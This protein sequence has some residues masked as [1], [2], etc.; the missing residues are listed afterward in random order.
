VWLLVYGTFLKTVIANPAAVLTDAAFSA[1]QTSGWTTVLGTLAFA[2]QI[3]CDFWAYSM[4]A[5]GSGRLLGIEFIWNFNQP[6]F[7]TSIQDFWRRWHISL[8]RWLRDYLYIPLGG[9]RKGRV[10]TYVNLIL[11][12]LLGGLWHGA[13]WSFVLW[14][15][16]HGLALAV[17]RAYEELLGPSRPRV[18]APIGWAVTM[19]VVLVGWFVFRCASW[20]MIAGMGRSLGNL[21]WTAGHTRTLATLACLAAPVFIVEVWQYLRRDLLAPLALREPHFAVL[22][23][24]MLALTIIMFGRFNYAFIYFQF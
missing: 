24:T 10:R 4:I 17:Q 18:P 1:Q 21:A 3:Y 15:L 20:A 19:L 8:S 23:G 16:L 5:R 22:C 7:A 2:I 14:G 11:T 13:A 6:Y 12:M 9:N